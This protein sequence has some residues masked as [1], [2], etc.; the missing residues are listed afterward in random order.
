MIYLYILQMLRFR[1]ICYI[2]PH[3]L[4]FVIG[5]RNSKCVC[6]KQSSLI[7]LSFRC[8]YKNNLFCSFH[9][10]FIYY[11]VFIIGLMIPT[12]CWTDD[13]H[14]V[15]DWWYPLDAGLMKPIGCPNVTVYLFRMLYIVF[16]YCWRMY[17]CNYLLCGEDPCK[18][19]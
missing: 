11:F 14:W 19:V 5:L 6:E 15:L 1:G 4:N 16:Y 7:K 8:L 10:T 18:L 3:I 9:I 17:Y 13:T 12:G 2:Y